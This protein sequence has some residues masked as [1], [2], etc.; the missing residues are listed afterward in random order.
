CFY[1]QSKFIEVRTKDAKS[2]LQKI[3]LPET[4]F[5][6]PSEPDVFEHSGRYYF[7]LEHQVM[8]LNPMKSAQAV[9]T[10]DNAAPEDCEATFESRPP[11]TV[12]P[13]KDSN[14]KNGFYVRMEGDDPDKII[15]Y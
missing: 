3:T 5:V 10:L 1:E 13:I 9:L 14:G 6:F 2:V 12:E 4:L 15:R 11:Y 7:G 8:W